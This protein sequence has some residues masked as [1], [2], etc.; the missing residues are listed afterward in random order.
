[1]IPLILR[2]ANRERGGRA[3]RGYAHR[4]GQGIVIMQAT[5]ES[6]GP[7]EADC[8]TSWRRRAQGQRAPRRLDLFCLPLR[9]L[10]VPRDL[11]ELRDPCQRLLP[12]LR[13]GRR[14]IP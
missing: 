8:A 1:M 11:P 12:G 13:K 14:C 9:Q 3:A 10:L 7:A 5:E 2:R 4:H 6:P